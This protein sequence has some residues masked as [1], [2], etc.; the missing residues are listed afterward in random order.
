MQSG[1]CQVREGRV[2]VLPGAGDDGQVRGL[3]RAPGRGRDLGRGEPDAAAKGEVE[4]RGHPQHV[5]DAL[6]FAEAAQPGVVPIDL[7]GGGPGDGGAAGQALSQDLG[8]QLRLGLEHQV[9]RQAHRLAASRVGDLLF[10]DLLRA[11]IRACPA[12]VA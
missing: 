9:L 2:A 1:I 10:R 7:I 12:G 11:P 5:A 4:V 8:G 6:A 3:S